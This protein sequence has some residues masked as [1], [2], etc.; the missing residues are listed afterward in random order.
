MPNY[1]NSIIYKLCCKDIL[2]TDIYV[3]STTNIVKR[4]HNHKSYCNNP[5]FEDYYLVIFHSRIRGHLNKYLYMFILYAL[6]WFLFF[7]GG[8]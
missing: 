3:G 6:K 1:A 7:F 4:R 2:I 5:S 8:I